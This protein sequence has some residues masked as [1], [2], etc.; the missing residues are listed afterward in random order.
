MRT[1]LY[2]Y[3]SFVSCHNMQPSGKARGVFLGICTL[4]VYDSFVGSG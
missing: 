1:L 2:M 3:T 4:V